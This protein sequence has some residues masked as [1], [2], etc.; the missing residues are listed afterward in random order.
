MS[1]LVLLNEGAGKADIFFGQKPVFTDWAY[2]LQHP[3]VIDIKGLVAEIVRKEP[4]AIASP[5]HP[6]LFVIQQLLRIALRRDKK[7]PLVTERTCSGCGHRKTDPALDECLYCHEESFLLPGNIWHE[8]SSERFTVMF[9]P[10]TDKWG[11]QF[12]HGYRDNKYVMWAVKGYASR[13]EAKLS[14]YPVVLFD[15][16]MR[17]K[18]KGIVG[19][20]MVE[21][22]SLDTLMSKLL[23]LNPIQFEALMKE[24]IAE[25]MDEDNNPFGGAI[26]WAINEY[27]RENSR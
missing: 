6:R 1:E 21:L 10:A 17:R 3:E 2:Y 24:K 9:D 15:D 14:S 5:D 27:D 20:N 23:P 26:E 4:V 18:T 22:I 13:M 11:L 19:M 12:K 7:L 25:R 16:W 8:W